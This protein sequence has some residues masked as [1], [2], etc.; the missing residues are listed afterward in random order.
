[1]KKSALVS[2]MFA[3]IFCAAAQE[4]PNERINV[5]LSGSGACT[6]NPTGAMVESSLRESIRSSSG[7]ALVDVQSPGNFLIALA[8]V[9]AGEKGEGWTA[10]A[11]HYGLLMKATPES[12]GTGIWNPTLGVFTVGRAH[13]QSKGQELFARFDNDLHR[14]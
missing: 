8:C 6:D 12:L 9:D 2:I 13:A 7:Y 14:P 5:Y 4:K 3:V 11:Y 1:M 10:V